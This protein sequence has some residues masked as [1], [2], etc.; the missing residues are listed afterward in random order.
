MLVASALFLFVL[1]SF[2]EIDLHSRGIFTR[3]DGYYFAIVALFFIGIVASY[4][5]GKSVATKK[6]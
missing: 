2:L 1:L 3:I 5:Y 6:V 4:L